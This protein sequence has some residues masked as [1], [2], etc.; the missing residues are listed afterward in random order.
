LNRFYT[1][2]FFLEAA[3][4][5]NPGGVLSFQVTAAENYIS[6]ELADLLKCLEKTLR[7]VFPQVV[8]IPGETVH[9]LATNRPG[10]LTLD[11]SE[12]MS[13][14]RQRRIRTQYVREYY[15]PFRM[16]PDR[17]QDLQVQIEPQPATPVNRDFTPIAYYF[18]VV[19]W[20]SKFHSH[21][22]ESLEHL[23]GLR[24][25]AVAGGV[26]LGLF[27]L[28]LVVGL[29]E[30]IR[31]ARHR[32]S[33]DSVSAGPH[34][35]GDVKSPLHRHRATVGLSVAAMGF[36]LLGLEVL[37]L[38]GFQALYGYVYKQLS[39]L[40]AVFMVGMAVGAWLSVAGASRPRWWERP[41]PARVRGQD[42]RPAGAGSETPALQPSDY[43]KLAFLQ[44]LAGLSP[45]LL[46]ALFVLLESVR[47][48]AALLTI[49]R[50]V[51]PM[52]ALIAGLM[53]GYQF[54]LA[55]RIYFAPSEE[56]RTPQ[57]GKEVHPSRAQRNPGV[58]YALDLLG[59]CLGAAALSAYLLPVYGFLR[60][61]M[62]MDVVNLAPAGLAG[63]A[64]LEA[65]YRRRPWASDWS[66]RQRRAP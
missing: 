45:L 31:V 3:E 23:A 24:F 65:R 34:Q 14:L 39:I 61:A 29:C 46:Y 37:L 47:S 53:G 15:L 66:A 58:L 25:G 8:A 32:S 16:S 50:L 63:L 49:S 20:S 43:V 56:P 4:K 42:A 28:A 35:A 40:V 60:T 22:R 9:F 52:L 26:A 13:R 33:A 62:L 6:Q 51:F 10:S 18:D 5:L 59:A 30:R 41:T 17:M 7:A 21:W 54:P 44:L 38:L 12:L 11:S 2:E 19:L 36:T 1:Q 64:A 57:G 27:G 48:L 55:S